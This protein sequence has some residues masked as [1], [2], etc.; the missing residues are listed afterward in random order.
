M[1]ARIAPDG[2]L[3]FVRNTKTGRVHILPWMPGEVVTIY[4]PHDPADTKRFIEAMFERTPMLCGT[5]LQVGADEYWP[6]VYVGGDEFAD[7]DLC[8][9]C[10]NALGGQS[11]LAF[12]ADNRGP[13]DEDFSIIRKSPMI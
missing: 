10:V 7:E 5:K 12:H 6:G 2:R 11:S 3:E 9:A 4:K 13:A 8:I 1:S